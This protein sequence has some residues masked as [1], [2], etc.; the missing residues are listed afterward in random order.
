MVDHILDRELL[1]ELADFL[2]HLI[3]LKVCLL[4]I[5]LL[6]HGL[7]L[8]FRFAFPLLSSFIVRFRCRRSA[9]FT[10]QVVRRALLGVSRGCAHHH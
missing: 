3:R 7:F 4:A 6:L 10:V 1:E 9:C 2:I 5:F 8:L